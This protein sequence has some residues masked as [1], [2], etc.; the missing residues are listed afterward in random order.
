M[1]VLFVLAV[2]CAPLAAEEY[3]TIYCEATWLLPDPDPDWEDWMAD[4][5]IVVTFT[6][7]TSISDY[8]YG[9]IASVDEQFAQ[10]MCPYL[11]ES[12]PHWI[13]VIARIPAQFIQGPNGEISHIQS[14]VQHYY[15]DR[16]AS[17]ILVFNLGQPLLQGD[18]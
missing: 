10:A 12:D 3:D 1:R 16:P 18:P 5:Q 4:A 2:L 9:A 17:G 14:Q 7:A 13:W 6:V 11:Y 8:T 15:G